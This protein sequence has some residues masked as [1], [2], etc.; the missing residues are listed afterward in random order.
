MFPYWMMTSLNGYR[1][2]PRTKSS[3]AELWCFFFICAW[4]N[5]WVN[6]RD[7]CDTITPIM[8]S[9]YWKWDKVG[10]RKHVSWNTRLSYIF[11]IIVA[12]LV[13]IYHDHMTWTSNSTYT[14]LP[15][16]TNAYCLHQNGSKCGPLPDSSKDTIIY[17]PP[18]TT[19]IATMNFHCTLN[20]RGISS[21]F[22]ISA[23]SP[24][25]KGGCVLLTQLMP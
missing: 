5:G 16:C 24:L 13:A 23:P 8:T 9:Q 6:D 18:L 7:F 21:D 25:A 10:S 15:M 22:V 14:K 2:I 11:N 3:A 19:G 20:V 4:I 17:S 1:G 12:D